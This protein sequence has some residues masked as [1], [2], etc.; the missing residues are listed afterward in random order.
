VGLDWIGVGGAGAGSGGFF[1][2][3]RDVVG[4]R[5]VGGGGGGWMDWG[6]GGELSTLHSER[7]FGGP[8][9]RYEEIA[10]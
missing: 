8:S 5:W 3:E 9:D 7:R 6:L 1:D 10:L 4:M 2:G